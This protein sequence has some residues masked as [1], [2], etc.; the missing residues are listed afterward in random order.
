MAV[1]NPRVPRRE[2]I[3][4][5]INTINNI[6]EGRSYFV[7][8]IEDDIN[9]KG[10]GKDIRDVDVVVTTEEDLKAI[11]EFYDFLYTKESIYNNFRVLQFDKYVCYDR[12]I[13]IDILYPHTDTSS[14]EVTTSEYYGTQVKHRTYEYK[15]ALIREFISMSNDDWVLDKFLPFLNRYE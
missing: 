13:K 9:L 2:E 6:T 14:V 1:K 12:D 10:V 7:G 8:S 4:D 3:L 11:C 5:I 15:S